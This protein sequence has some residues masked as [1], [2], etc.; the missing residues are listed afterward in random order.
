MITYTG[1]PDPQLM[2][3]LNWRESFFLLHVQA[4]QGAAGIRMQTVTQFLGGP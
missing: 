1:L 3:A 2:A 4:F